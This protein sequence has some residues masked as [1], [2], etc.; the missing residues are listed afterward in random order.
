M[1][2]GCELVI[3]SSA[4]VPQH[5]EPHDPRGCVPGNGVPLFLNQGQ[6]SLHEQTQLYGTPITFF[7]PL[8]P[9]FYR[10]A[11][12]LDCTNNNITLCPHKLTIIRTR[13]P[14]A[15]LSIIGEYPQVML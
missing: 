7:L 12:C 5:K 3:V 14:T 2:N 10:C 6:C 9:S 1:A 11:L 8:H 15:M 4:S 13:L